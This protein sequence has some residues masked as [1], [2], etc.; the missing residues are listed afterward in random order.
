MGDPGLEPVTS[1]V[2]YSPEAPTKPAENTWISGRVS[3]PPTFASLFILLRR[4]LP[5]DGIAAAR[6]E[7]S[8]MCRPAEDAPGQ[9]QGV[10]V[11]PARRKRGSG[12]RRCA[13]GH[14]ARGGWAASA[15]GKNCVLRRGRVSKS[16]ID[17]GG[18][19]EGR[20]LF[21]RTAPRSCFASWRPRMP[22]DASR[23]VT[24]RPARRRR[25]SVSPAFAGGHLRSG[26]RRAKKKRRR[27]KGEHFPPG[28]IRLRFTSNDR[29]RSRES[30]AG[31]GMFIGRGRRRAPP[32]PGA[33]PR[34]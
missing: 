11:R 10:T 2:S 15:S 8:T 1:S 6:V 23:G 17:P 33:P 12:Q 4:L 19:E 26:P 30:S 32:Y 13:F 22:Q 7:D 28:L 25:G 18:A 29:R 14:L 20:R 21:N 27:P 5:C 24:V 3:L 9:T 31:T 34:V 16:S